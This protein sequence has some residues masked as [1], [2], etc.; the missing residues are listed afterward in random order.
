VGK[1][2]PI[3]NSIRSSR[4]RGKR[5]LPLSIDKIL[6]W[7]DEHHDRTGKWPNIKLG[8]VRLEPSTPWQ[9]VDMAI[10]MGYRGLPG[11]SS[12]A[13]LLAKHRGVRNRGRL[14][15]LTIDQILAWADA[16]YVRTAQWPNSVSGPVAEAPG[17]T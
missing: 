11:G 6:A 12:L 13:Q 14:P 16:H 8:R 9:A 7:A 15:L 3:S 10:N 4:R 1:Q 17:E 5:P 2:K